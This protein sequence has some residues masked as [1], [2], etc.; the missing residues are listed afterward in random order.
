MISWPPAHLRSLLALPGLAVLMAV[1]LTTLMPVVHAATLTVTTLTD[2]NDHR[3]DDG[4]C[5]LRDAI[6]IATPDDTITFGVTGTI[7]LTLGPV[8]IDKNLTL[9]GPGAGQLT[10]SGNN[11]NRVFYIS[12]TASVN[13]LGITIANGRANDFGG[14]IYNAGSLNVSDSTFVN[15]LVSSDDI[16]T[17]VI[18]GGGLYNRGVLSLTNSIFLDNIAASG[19]VA[20]RGG[21]LYN[22]GILQVISTTFSRNSALD[23]GG[24]GNAPG[25]VLEISDSTFSGNRGRYGGA[26]RNWGTLTVS[27]STFSDNGT[28]A[29]EGGGIFNGGVSTVAGST[30]THNRAGVGGALSNGEG[31]LHLV[32]ST[33]AS[34]QATGVGGGIYNASLLTVTN[35]TLSGN[36]AGG[37]GGGVHNYDTATLVNTIVAQSTMGGN[38]A[39]R[40]PTRSSNHNLSTD[41][42]CSGGFT[43]VSVAQLALGALTGSPAY[44][45][46]NAGSVAID[47]GNNSG[48]PL[49]DQRGMPR[50][51]DGNGDGVA[52]CDVGSY[53]VMLTGRTAV[54][55]RAVR[56]PT[57]DGNLAEW[58][59]M[60]LVVLNATTADTVAGQ[61][62]LSPADSS[63]SLRAAWDAA[64][65]YFAIHVNDDQLWSDSEDI[66]RDDGVEIAI[67]GDLS[68]TRNGTTDHLYTLNQDGRHTDW[69]ITL[70]VGSYLTQAVPGGYDIEFAIPVTQV[71][72]RSAFSTGLMMG[73]TWA[74]HDDDDGGNWDT[75]LIWEGNQTTTNY[76]LFGQLLLSIVPIEFPTP[77]ST[78]TPTAT[79]T[80]VPSPTP[81]ATNTFT[82][83]PTR[84]STTTP[85]STTSPTGTA[86][87]TATPTGVQ[88][89]TPT[90]TATPSA[91]PTD[92]PSHT[93]T[94]TDTPTAS[95]TPTTPPYRVHLPLVWRIFHG[96][97]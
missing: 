84:T 65:L 74:V 68:R 2:E 85:T 87:P 8:V 89:N 90:S 81:T 97:W 34:N 67:D 63:A 55:Y 11:V 14:G 91:I 33:L 70:T 35:S 54:A 25:G 96:G 71:L 92:T 73:F 59:A 80:S 94:P 36:S 75:W 79:A 58:P 41:A 49:T 43:R 6:E 56:P 30:F 5:S 19:A 83:T 29:G 20:A 28:D 72:R 17:P 21:G 60:G 39:G 48:C 1:T 10:V 69:G 7:T 38:C 86:T 53:E 16:S 13:L 51:R 46:L 77:T 66:W 40:A 57:L 45:P 62:P 93:P 44:F 18:G 24:I 50:P 76:H 95:P 4:D 61:P 3:C 27:N 22:Q 42:T 47:A 78:P 82:P 52:I 26:I 32:N 12:N 88:S 15:N 64:N 37:G 23:G 31:R 9:N